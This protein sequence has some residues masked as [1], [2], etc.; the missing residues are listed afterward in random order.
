MKPTTIKLQLEIRVPPYPRV[1]MTRIKTPGKKDRVLMGNAKGHKELTAF[2]AEL[3]E[4]IPAHAK[5]KLEGSISLDVVVGIS[6]SQ[7]DLSNVLKS[8]EDAFTKVGIW[9]DDRY[10]D[11]IAIRRVRVA[12]GFDYLR[13][14]ITG[15][16]PAL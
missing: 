3:D 10:V 11:S 6:S 12:K 7:G 8:I 1:Q 2:Y 5:L 16:P 13:A 14:T 9:R 4:R 15:T